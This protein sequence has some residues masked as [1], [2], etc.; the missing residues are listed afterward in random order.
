MPRTR[1]NTPPA[2][3]SAPP[4]GQ[5]DLTTQEGA[6]PVPPTEAPKP[7]PPIPPP[8]TDTEANKEKDDSPPQED[9]PQDPQEPIRQESP[10]NEKEQTADTHEE[11]DQAAGDDDKSNRDE[12]SR[13]DSDHPESEDHHDKRS[14]GESLAT[15]GD[16]DDDDYVEQEDDIS[17]GCGNHELNWWRN[18][19]SAK[20]VETDQIKDIIES[21]RVTVT[22]KNGEP[23]LGFHFQSLDDEIAQPDN[24]YFIK[25]TGNYFRSNES[26]TYVLEVMT[27]VLAYCS[28]MRIENGLGHHPNKKAS[29]TP[30][31]LK[32][33]NFLNH[34]LIMKVK[35]VPG[36][37]D[38]GTRYKRTYSNILRGYATTPNGPGVN[39][40][41]HRI[42]YLFALYRLGV[43]PQYQYHGDE[44]DHGLQA[45]RW[46]F[47]HSMSQTE[48]TKQGAWCLL[49]LR[50]FSDHLVHRNMPP[51]NIPMD[52]E[53]P[54]SL[55]AIERTQNTR[56]KKVPNSDPT[57]KFDMYG[58]ETRPNVRK[59]LKR[60]IIAYERDHEQMFQSEID[61][62]EHSPNKYKQGGKQ[63]S[64]KHV[65]F[66]L[67]TIDGKLVG[68]TFIKDKGT[69]SSTA[70][71][72]SPHKRRADSTF[73][74]SRKAPRQS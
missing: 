9:P 36:V 64:G 66:A 73:E 52:D 45:V 39:K 59:A 41:M 1:R 12:P 13:S 49:A 31:L 70:S 56:Y 4:Q 5:L 3:P 40:Y 16:D 67:A 14:D 43:S 35:Y 33:L 38:I 74:S 23:D 63:K 47:L 72:P 6:P 54:D 29:V 60:A 15:E 7:V 44:F 17:I 46:T 58:V 30:Y 51:L 71:T 20:P 25:N 8:H 61:F 55:K 68:T 53:T 24:V 32:A 69:T 50:L 48:T 27:K 2:D 18:D 22:F 34:E 21:A 19:A 10:L 57:K 26:G 37:Q 65:Q 62:I 28:K 11:E 42:L